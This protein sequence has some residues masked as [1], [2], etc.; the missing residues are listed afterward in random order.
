MK[1]LFTLTLIL[2]FCHVSLGQTDAIDKSDLD[3]LYIRTLRHQFDLLLSSGHK[4]FEVNE[5]TARIKDKI[6]VPVYSF[7]SEE[8]LIDK[9]IKNNGSLT[10]YRVT[11]KVISQDT[12]DINIS[13]V[14]LTAKRSLHFDNGLK[15]KRAHYLIPCGGTNGYVPTARYAF[16]PNTKAWT[17]TE[18]IRPRDYRDILREQREN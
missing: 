17:E 10:V 13:S 2:G 11:H 5:N 16:D 7:L 6:D 3:I 8:Q 4:Y 18:Y 14:V 12:I 15:T 1:G 9:A